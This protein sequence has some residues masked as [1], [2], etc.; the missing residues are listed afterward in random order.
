MLKI[1]EKMLVTKEGFEDKN[2]S[3][4]SL[5]IFTNQWTMNVT[6]LL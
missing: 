6:L 4:F 3:Y 2:K 1:K 5:K